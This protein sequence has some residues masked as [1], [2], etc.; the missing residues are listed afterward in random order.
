MKLNAY[1]HKPKVKFFG[2]G[3]W[4]VGIEL[5]V[6][7]KDR[8][9]M[10]AGLA[11]RNRPSSI[12]AK[13]DG[14]LGPNGWELVTQP[15]SPELWLKPHKRLWRGKPHGGNIAG[16][17]LLTVEALRN[18]GYNS[19]NGGRCGLHL[20]VCAKAFGQQYENGSASHVAEHTQHLRMFRRL[21]HGDLFAQLSQRESF[22]YC[23]RR[24]EQVASPDYRQAVRYEAVNICSKTVEVRIFRGNM[25]EDR[26]LA[27]VEAVIA[28]VEYTKILTA[29]L[30]AADMTADQIDA[31]F[32][33][34]VRSNAKTY[35]NLNARL[36]ELG[37]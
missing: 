10:N 30:A 6:E 7:A 19:Y 1:S 22:G 8:D 36:I 28:G 9:G 15:I 21:V 24:P 12:C 16:R 3:P 4:Y 23:Q 31:G 29:T 33:A 11:L 20:H 18:I 37:R 27:A 35:Q 5:E 13:H 17:V 32:V 25:R 2:K 14:S 26:I 34:Y